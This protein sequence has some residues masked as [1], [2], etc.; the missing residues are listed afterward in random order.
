[1]SDLEKLK[2]LKPGGYILY[3]WNYGSIQDVRALTGMLSDV[4]QLKT[5]F[6]WE[7]REKIRP[8]IC[9][10]QEGGR[11]AA[12]RF[13][14]FTLPPAAFRPGFPFGARLVEESAYSTALELRYLD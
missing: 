3:P 10:D 11:V 13:K 9:A 12:F 4:A 14:E 7:W 5:N 6:P 2:E 1:V 8:F